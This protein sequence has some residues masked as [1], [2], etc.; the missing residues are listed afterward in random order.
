MKGYPQENF[1]RIMNPLA[2]YI[3]GGCDSKQ[4]RIKGFTIGELETYD[5]YHVNHVLQTTKPQGLVSLE[6]GKEA[7]K[8]YPSFEQY[9]KIKEIEGLKAARKYWTDI[10]EMQKIAV[11]EM[12]SD[13]GIDYIKAKEKEEEFEDLVKSIDGWLVE[14]D[15]ELETKI[16][17]K[18]S[19]NR[20][21]SKK[22]EVVKKDIAKTV[23][24]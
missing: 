20:P 6:Y 19:L 16:V 1:R 13:G 2:W 15:A 12:K 18:V 24:A 10:L 3:E 5:V 22:K 4:Y 23:G 21:T 9:M 8:Q 14:A 7:R 11:E 17:E